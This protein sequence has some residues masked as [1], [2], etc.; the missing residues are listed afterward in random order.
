MAGPLRCSRC[1]A[2]SALACYSALAQLRCN[3]P[4]SL[5]LTL[6]RSNSIDDIADKEELW[7]VMGEGNEDA[8]RAAIRAASQLDDRYLTRVYAFWAM[9]E[10][11]SCAVR[12][13]L[14]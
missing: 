9:G 2:A 10:F 5:C 8:V 11:L 12:V 4:S 6:C 1:A 13:C 14:C 7:A 3:D